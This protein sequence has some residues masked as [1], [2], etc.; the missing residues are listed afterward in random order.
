MDCIIGIHAGT[1]IEDL[2]HQY[3]SRFKNDDKKGSVSDSALISLSLNL[4]MMFNPIIGCS[5]EN[6]FY[7][8][9]HNPYF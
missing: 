3:W 9:G 6:F 1:I 7:E 5:Q 2:S 8:A 4:A